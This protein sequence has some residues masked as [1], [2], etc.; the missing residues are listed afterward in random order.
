MALERAGE[1]PDPIGKGTAVY[2]LFKR[3]VL[4]Q[5]YGAFPNTIQEQMEKDDIWVSL[6]RVTEIHTM[7]SSVLSQVTQVFPLQAAAY[8]HRDGYIETVY[9]RRRHFP[10][11]HPRDRGMVRQAVNFAM[12]QS[13]GFDIIKHIILR[14][15]REFRQGGLLAR[16]IGQ[17]HDEIMVLCPDA[18]IHRVAGIMRDAFCDPDLTQPFPHRV[19]LGVEVATGKRYGSLVTYD[20][21]AVSQP[22]NVVVQED[23][24]AAYIRIV[25]EALPC[26]KCDFFAPYG[27]GKVGV[28]G[29]L[30]VPCD[31]AWVG[32]NPGLEEMEAGAPFFGRS[33]RFL[34]QSA[35]DAGLP[36]PPLPGA[37]FMNALWCGSESSQGILAT[38][39]ANCRPFLDRTLAIVR[40]KIIV[41][42]GNVA[43]RAVL[44][45]HG[46]IGM[47]Q[48]HGTWHDSPIGARV[49]VCYHPAFI[50][51]SPG[52]GGDFVRAL[53][54]V[55][56][57]LTALRL[58]VP[59]RRPGS[60]GGIVSEVAFVGVAR[61]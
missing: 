56:D 20:F 28:A 18:E 30:S 38:H 2:E 40:P 3:C 6:D 13:P 10:N 11:F 36:I 49:L 27:W 47:E 55:S 15:A 4:G 25:R 9:H 23:P 16:M 50:L 5:G 19:P 58:P 35:Y 61:A 57:A 14:V 22:T 33:G 51:R 60:S 32:S 43:A 46:D 45:V 53:G 39:I 54:M 31:I 41:A 21:D 12:G 24:R 37:I 7:V 52:F 17:I 59:A 44:R 48:M 26:T 1:P 8:I 29:N 34:R 42:L